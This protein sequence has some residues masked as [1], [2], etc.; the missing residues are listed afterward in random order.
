MVRVG[1]REAW[2]GEE[3][4]RDWEINNSWEGGVPHEE[5]REVI[6]WDCWDDDFVGEKGCL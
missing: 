3:V 2:R 4:A 5:F 1:R 6:C